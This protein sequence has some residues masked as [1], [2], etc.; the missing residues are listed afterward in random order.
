MN[1]PKTN[2]DFLDELNRKI[3]ERIQEAHAEKHLGNK[4]KKDRRMIQFGTVIAVLVIG[5][6]IINLPV[7]KIQHV[8]V[9]NNVTIPTKKIDALFLKTYKNKNM[10]FTFKNGMEQTLEKSNGI[11][12]VSVQKKF[13]NTVEIDVD[14]NFCIGLVEA[15]DR[16]FHPM[17]SDGTYGTVS[18]AKTVAAPIITNFSRE[19]LEKGLYKE[20]KKL[21]F[22]ILQQISTITF[23]GDEIYYNRLVLTM[24]DGNYV[25]LDMDN[26]EEKMSYYKI[27][28]ANKN[29]QY[30]ISAIGTFYLEKVMGSDTDNIDYFERGKPQ[31]TSR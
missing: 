8:V 22:D 11:K 4:R 16:K 5:I 27:L 31:L 7:F 2:S 28:V 6:I 14:E 18:D 30:G 12:K 17:Y 29:K 24:N 10:I 1:N 21:D 3:E 20:L 26:L 19:D 13:P 25:V 9:K 15:D 23:S